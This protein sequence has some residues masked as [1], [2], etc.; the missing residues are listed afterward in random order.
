MVFACS[1]WGPQNTAADDAP[2]VYHNPDRIRVGTTLLY[3]PPNKPA[4]WN[5]LLV[6]ILNMSP[7][8]QLYVK[9]RKNE[10]S[11]DP[12]YRYDYIKGSELPLYWVE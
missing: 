4:Q 2:S 7:G 6:L 5:A 11:E 10:C 9:T 1:S 8:Q 3:F 12:Y